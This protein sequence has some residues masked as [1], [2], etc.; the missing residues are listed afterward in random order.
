MGNKKK[1]SMVASTLIIMMTILTFTILLPS[2]VKADSPE[3]VVKVE[4]AGGYTGTIKGD[5]IEYIEHEGTHEFSVTGDII[6]VHLTKAGEDYYE[7]KVTIL[8][9]GNVRISKS[10]SEPNGE[11]SLSYSLRAEGDPTEGDDDE[12]NSDEGCG[13]LCVEALLLPVVAIL[14]GLL[15]ITRVK[16]NS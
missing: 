12:E 6:H 1:I 10:T 16:K 7:M 15:L 14:A 13:F 8:V 5:V 2:D 4:H 11:L 9:D 3:A